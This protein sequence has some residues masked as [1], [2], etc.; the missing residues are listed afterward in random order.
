MEG[1]GRGDGGLAPPIAEPATV[2]RN[3]SPKARRHSAVVGT[4]ADRHEDEIPEDL[5][6]ALGREGVAAA[7]AVRRRVQERLL[8]GIGGAHACDRVVCGSYGEG[9]V[10]GVCM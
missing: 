9:C 3:D 7:A 5:G 8:R 1:L 2:L 10:G 4:K 6:R